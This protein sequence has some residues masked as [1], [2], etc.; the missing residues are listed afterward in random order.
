MAS[1]MRLRRDDG[2]VYL[3]RW[4]V[5]WKRLGGIFLHKMEAPDPGWWLHDHPFSFVSFIVKGGYWEERNV[6]ELAV[7]DARYA[8]SV[9]ILHNGRRVGLAPRGDRV[10]RSRWSFK[11]LGLDECHRITQLIGKTSWS[12]IIHGPN[13]TDRPDGAKWG[14][15]TPE[16]WVGGQDFRQEDRALE[17]EI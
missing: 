11:T 17:N 7:N 9:D 14:F 4:G 3:N 2:Q 5:E 1:R 8:Q 6:V 15:Y 12:I 16:G 13:R 10:K